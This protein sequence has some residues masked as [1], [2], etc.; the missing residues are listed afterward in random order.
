MA[1]VLLHGPGRPLRSS[2]V[3][4]PTPGYGQVL[5]RVG[6]CGVCRTDLHV[7]DGEL[8]HPKLPLILGHEIVGRVEQL[9][10][11]VQQF[12]TGERI[13]IPWLG[14]TCG[15]CRYCQQGRENLCSQAR[16]TGYTVDGGYAE[17]TVADAR[18]CFRLPRSYDDVTVAPLLCAGLIGFR[19]Y[20]LAGEVERLGI[21][22][23]GAAAHILTQV[24]VHQG[25][26]VFAF[27]RSG[28]ADGQAF[29]LQ[30]GAEW[31][32][33]STTRPPE[34]LDATLIFAP[35]GELLP[36]ALEATD[37]G[38]TVVC[39]G[40]HMTDIPSFPYSLLWG[41]RVVRSVANLTR[42][43]AETF[44][45]LAGEVPIRTAVEPYPLAAA[46]EALDRLRAGRV[47]GAAVLVP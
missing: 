22:G 41:E 16:F 31:V 28:D 20:R 21:Y 23:F 34:P 30:L 10:D 24:A 2:R 5:V 11:G 9:G 44:L 12:S 25:K 46:N 7:L 6:A 47:K 35:V 4:A 33:D 27:T 13:G 43:D 38:G 15:E 45:R 42:L 14:W 8:A 36:L 1:A 17:W 37:R 19:A 18:Y 40:I 3:A 29:A 39:A 26:R 32:G